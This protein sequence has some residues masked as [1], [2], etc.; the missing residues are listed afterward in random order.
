MQQEQHS[1]SFWI[2]VKMKAKRDV[3]ASG[4]FGYA[5]W[6]TRQPTRDTIV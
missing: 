3:S 5:A 1:M 4:C 6:P 2:N